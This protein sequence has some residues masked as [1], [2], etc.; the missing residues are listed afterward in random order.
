M[1]RRIMK[2]FEKLEHQHK[3]HLTPQQYEAVIHT[4]GYNLLLACPGSGKTTV[5]VVKTA[6]LISEKGIA[7]NRI[8]T[9]TFS[10]AAA[11]D[12]QNRYDKLFGETLSKANFSTIHSFCFKIM[13]HYFSKQGIR[14]E[15]L[16]GQNSKSLTKNKVIVQL[17]ERLVGSKPTED[18]V[19]EL[20]GTISYFKN[21]MVPVEEFDSYNTG[22]RNIK[23]MYTA[24]E[25]FNRENNLY[26]YDDMLLI[27]HQTLKEDKS[28]LKRYRQQF[29]YIQVDE[30]Q[31]NSKIQNEIVRLLA[32]SEKNLFMVADDDQTIYEWRGSDPEGVLRFSDDYPGAHIYKMEQNFRSSQDIV[33]LSNQ[34]IKNNQNRY[35]KNLMTQNPTYQPIELVKL[36]LF[37]DQ[38]S[39]II[40]SLKK[41]KGRLS[42]YAVLFRN[43]L[44]AIA[45]ANELDLEGIDFCVKGYSGHFFTHWILNDIKD[46]LMFSLQPNRTELFDRI[47][48][49]NDAFISRKVYETAKM[50]QRG[51]TSIFDEICHMSELQV[52]QKKKISGLKQQFKA[53]ANKSMAHAIEHIEIQLGYRKWLEGSA[54]RLGVSIEG[55]KNILSI[56]KQISKGCS[57]FEGFI[58]RMDVLQRRLAASINNTKPN[59]LVLSTLHSSKGLEFDAVYMM[60]LVKGI[61]PSEE[62]LQKRKL[63][64]AERRLFYVGMTR[65]RYNLY[66]LSGNDKVIGPSLFIKEVDQIQH[67]E[68]YEVHYIKEKEK[69]YGL[70][71]SLHKP[72]K[73]LKKSD[74]LQA[75]DFKKNDSVKHATYGLGR[76]TEMLE[77]CIV[78]EFANGESKRFGLKFVLEKQLIEKV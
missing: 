2:F 38:Y 25:A 68:K 34:F 14:K 12:M 13:L 71:K 20:A 75:I 44:S 39:Y 32:A 27:C 8:L 59:A 50:N 31:D 28:L 45:L 4:E 67:P 66:L 41:K 40:K 72:K 61:F 37:E 1:V 73:T 16:E 48:Y 52:Y 76:V 56:I 22:V 43:N 58:Q 42:K 24:Y 74:R 57:D 60:D 6:Y 51:N 15:N 17:F 5:M 26:D 46:F 21:L 33:S 70:G 62:A 18:V 49:K 19:E 64:E 3:I 63:L 23:E 78:I 7:P 10:K 69:I 55:A 11:L 36:G 65:A 35:E 29:D 77:T 54:G 30:A 47:Y 9:I 53:L